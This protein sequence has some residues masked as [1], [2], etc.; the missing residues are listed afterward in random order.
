MGVVMEI[1]EATVKGKFQITLPK[2][3]RK[4]MGLKEGDTI[5]FLN[6]G[7][8]AHLVRK[9]KAEEFIKKMKQLSGGRRFPG[10]VKE[11]IKERKEM[12]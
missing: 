9:P 5:A 6:E 11:F 10:A 8:S 4:A 12:W 1:P 2:E 7:E 3:T